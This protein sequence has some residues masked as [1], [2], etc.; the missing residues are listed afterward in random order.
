[1]PSIITNKLKEVN[2]KNFI[3]N[4]EKENLYISFG[5]SIAWT[6][7][8]VPPSPVD[9]Y[10]LH[11][12]ILFDQLYMKKVVGGNVS[13]VARIY[14]W[15]PN[16]RY[17]QYSQ[18]VHIERLCEPKL[19]SRATATAVLS[20]SSV[21]Q[22]NVINGGSGYETA[23]NVSISG[24]GGSG[25]TAQAIVVDG[26]VVSI[27]VTAGGSGYTSAPTITIDPPRGDISS[28]SFVVQPYYVITDEMNVYVC[29]SN[30]NFALSTIKPTS[31][32][33]NEPDT[34]GTALAD[35]YV[36]KYV[37]TVPENEAEKF[38]TTNWFPVKNCSEDDS[39]NN[40]LIQ[41][42]STENNRIHGFDIP[43]AF[44]ATALMIKVRI[45]G[46]EGGKIISSNDYRKISLIHNPVAV[47]SVFK[48][49]SAGANTLVLNSLHDIS[50]TNA[51]WYPTVGKKIIILEGPGRGQIRTITAFNPSTRTVTVNENWTYSLTS[52]TKYGILLSSLVANL[53]TVLTL[54]SVS[55]SFTPDETATQSSSSANGKIVAFDSV[56][57]KL[58][59]TNVT[60]EFKTSAQGG[61]PIQQGSATATI[62]AVTLPEAQAYFN[63]V[64]FTENRRKIIRNLDQIEDI[65]IV[66]QF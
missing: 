31:T 3:D 65:K 42:N 47:K 17:Q 22:I 52:D 27:V 8:N 18:T 2:I 41:Y 26:V 50:D 61:S 14:R 60:G 7:E 39:S 35:G 25:A 19:Y 63:N 48:C 56:T 32:N 49:D 16:T 24:G 29:I 28:T 15:T 12:N 64:L 1:M 38:M 54:T 46:D 43:Y 30:N 59:L 21:L 53:C 44:N 37:Y 45:S 13:R 9:N 34:G 5:G 11:K 51:L 62:S 23:P 20:G 55:G 33:T 4:I 36:W 40:W 6:N 66:I 10:N 57:N 58:Y